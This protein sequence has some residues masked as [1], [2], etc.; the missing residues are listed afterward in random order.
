MS[1]Q[2]DPVSVLFDAGAARLLRRAY[3]RPGAW[4]GTRVK[5][6]EA[7]QV[8]FALYR[9]IN[10]YRPDP[11]AG[12]RWTRA[13]IRSLYHLNTWY[14]WAGQLQGGRRRMYK[15]PQAIRYQVGSRNAQGWP[16]RVMVAAGSAAGYGRVPAAASYVR[17]ESARSVPEDRDW[18]WQ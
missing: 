11:G 4:A 9:G 3:D 5:P 1:Y 7:S 18:E 6:P 12:D 14:V 13:F 16:V 17:S 10:L 2:R 15:N 8:A